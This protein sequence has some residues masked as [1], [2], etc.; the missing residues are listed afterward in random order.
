MV[1]G[2]HHSH[3]LR[4]PCVNHS[5]MLPLLAREIEETIKVNRLEIPTCTWCG[6]RLFSLICMHEL[7][8]I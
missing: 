7:H 4:S 1:L 3:L 2:K 5:S 6:N 8:T